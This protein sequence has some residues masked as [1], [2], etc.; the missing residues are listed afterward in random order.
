MAKNI[1]P[2]TSVTASTLKSQ[3]ES[4]VV[5]NIDNPLLDQAASWVGPTATRVLNQSRQAVDAGVQEHIKNKIGKDGA[6]IVKTLE[7]N[8]SLKQNLAKIMDS[9][10]NLTP[11]QSLQ[12]LE[13][14]QTNNPA[15]FSQLKDIM[16]AEGFE[17]VIG[18][19]ANSPILSL[20]DKKD[21]STAEAPEKLIADLSEKLKENPQFLV[22]TEQLLD[23]HKELINTAAQNPEALQQMLQLT[24]GAT[25]S[26]ST[27]EMIDYAIQNKDLLET[28]A[29]F[30][31]IW[32]HIQA[33][34]WSA[35]FAEII[36]MV[37]DY[38]VPYLEPF[39]KDIE[40]Y[41]KYMEPVLGK[42]MTADLVQKFN[43][44]A[45]EIKNEKASE[46]KNENTAE[47]KAENNQEPA[48]TPKPTEPTAEIK[49]EEKPEAPKKETASYETPETSILPEGVFDNITSQEQFAMSSAPVPGIVFGPNG[50]YDLPTPASEQPDITK[51]PAFGMNSMVT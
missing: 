21:G 9:E 47:S 13:D 10:A 28:G 12:A 33:G 16:K 2:L 11:E 37:M 14:L 50:E 26:L 5:N 46:I 40:P 6:D 38:M 17:S 23:Q 49:L 8:Q 51:Q 44:K 19:L 3:A 1:G 7:N 32:Q 31:G 36:E 42:E 30:M 39:V 35:A 34:D 41:S 43:E 4:I 20:I 27:V 25:G 22:E 48:E 15:V 29:T 18:K 24:G 45:S